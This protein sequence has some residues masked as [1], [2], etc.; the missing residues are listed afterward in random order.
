LKFIIIMKKIFLTVLAVMLITGPS[1]FSFAQ[2][3]TSVLD[4]VESVNAKVS[5]LEKNQNQE[6]V[7]VTI[8]LLANNGEKT[9]WRFLD[10]AFKYEALVLG[11]SRVSKLKI[12][13]D[14]KGIKDWEPVDE[15]SSAKPLLRIE[16]PEYGQYEF[17]VSASEFKPGNNTGHFALILY[18]KNPEK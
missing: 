17:I 1:K 9:I 16:P 18:H 8:D 13:V 14:K 15:L 12:K 6:V 4:M 2:S 7:N 10:P 3:A 5:E 11:D